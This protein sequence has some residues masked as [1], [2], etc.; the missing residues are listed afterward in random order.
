MLALGNERFLLFHIALIGPVPRVS[1]CSKVDEK[2]NPECS[3]I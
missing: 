3:D 1:A 2:V